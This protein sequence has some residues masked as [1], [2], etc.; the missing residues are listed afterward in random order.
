MPVAEHGG[1]AMLPR[2]GITRALYPEEMA[3]T[4]RKKPARKYRIVRAGRSARLC[5]NSH[6]ATKNTSVCRLS[7]R[8]ARADR[9]NLSTFY[10]LD[11]F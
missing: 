6:T 5:P 8:R 10:I 2:I 4:P 7:N 1:D 11:L 3:P 9:S